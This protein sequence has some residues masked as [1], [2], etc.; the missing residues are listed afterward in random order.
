MDQKPFIGVHNTYHNSLVNDEI[1]ATGASW[2][3][4]AR[5]YGHTDEHLIK[6]FQMGV[7]YAYPENAPIYNMFYTPDTL[8]FYKKAMYDLRYN[9]RTHY[10]AIHDLG[11]WGLDI[12]HPD[13]QH[14]VSQIEKGA[15]LLNRFNPPK[16]KV[17][18]LVVFG[19]EG[20]CNWYPNKDLIA[21]SII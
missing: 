5:D 12:Q 10:H 14:T 11:R 19:M 2:W 15:K 7:S 9:I 4:I 8:E 17:D 3:K 1:W 18:L 6:P 16:P 13:F 20:L 21:I